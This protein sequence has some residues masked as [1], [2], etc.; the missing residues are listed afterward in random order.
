MII[1]VWDC[2]VTSIYLKLID[3]LHKYKNKFRGEKFDNKDY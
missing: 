2:W 3:I 1:I